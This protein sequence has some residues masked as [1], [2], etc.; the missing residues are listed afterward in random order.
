[1]AVCYS[2]ELKASLRGI[3]FYQ[4][5]VD[6]WPD[7]EHA[8]L[9]Q[10]LIGKYYERAKRTGE[11]GADEAEVQIER[12]YGAV[13]E[14]YGDSYLAKRAALYLGMLRF[15]E[16]NWSKAVEYFEW[17]AARAPQELNRVVI[18]LGR[19]YEQ[20]GQS[21]RAFAL[22]VDFLNTAAPGDPLVPY[23]E[24]QLQTLPEDQP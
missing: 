3:E 17:F 16:G 18:S 9:A 1:V 19:A 23:I 10:F 13:M 15:G 14:N 11:L 4:A 5:L 7:W 21:V 8:D 2:Q 22:Y 20:L 24:K 12:G 6:I